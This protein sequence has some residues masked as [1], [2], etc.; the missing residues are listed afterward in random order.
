[1]EARATEVENGR[2]AKAVE[3]GRQRRW[4]PCGGKKGDDSRGTTMKQARRKEAK[5]PRSKTQDAIR[6]R[7]K[8]A[9]RKE[10]KKQDIRRKRRKRSKEVSKQDGRRIEAKNQ[11]SKAQAV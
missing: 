8:D 3:E 5:K 2:E 6:Q 4:H 1:M 7:R 9:R 11:R 10:A